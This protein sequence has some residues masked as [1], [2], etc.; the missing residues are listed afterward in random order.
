MRKPPTRRSLEEEMMGFLIGS[1]YS[2]KPNPNI[3]WYIYIVEPEYETEIGKHIHDH[4]TKISNRLGTE[5][6]I[7]LGHTPAVSDNISAFLLKYLSSDVQ[8]DVAKMISGKV[9]ALVTRKPLPNTDAMALL[10]ICD[11]QGPLDQGVA[12]LDQIVDAIARGSFES[13]VNASEGVKIQQGDFAL[14]TTDA[15][16]MFLKRAAEFV[17]VKIPLIFFDIELSKILG[18]FLAKYPKINV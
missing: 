11:S 6:A 18:Y 15:G 4:F 8:I 12:R 16:I 5:A 13:F 17:P 7:I 14:L 1:L 9:S 2:V 10:P 3:E